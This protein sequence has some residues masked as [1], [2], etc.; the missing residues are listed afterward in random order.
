MYANEK[1]F[2]DLAGQAVSAILVADK[3]DVD[4]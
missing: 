4:T 3:D 2:Y 1:V